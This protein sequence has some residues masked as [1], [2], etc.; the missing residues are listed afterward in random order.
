M[1]SACL[2]EGMNKDFRFSIGDGIDA[3][4]VKPLRGL[5]AVPRLP[6]SDLSLVFCIANFQSVFDFVDRDH[7]GPVWP[8][9][10]GGNQ[11]AFGG[12]FG[13][14]LNRLKFV[15]RLHVPEGFGPAFVRV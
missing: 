4:K 3:M 6:H 7:V 11:L 5:L 14:G 8:V 1:F 9:R 2:A 15:G 10:L 13:N 12:D